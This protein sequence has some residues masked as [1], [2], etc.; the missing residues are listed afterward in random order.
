M[1]LA[2]GFLDALEADFEHIAPTAFTDGRDNAAPKAKLAVVKDWATMKNL[3]DK[4]FPQIPPSEYRLGPKSSSHQRLK[5]A[6]KRENFVGKVR[7]MSPERGGHGSANAKGSVAEGSSVVLVSDLAAL[8][9]PKYD[10]SVLSNN[11]TR[12]T[13]YDEEE[14]DDEE[15]AAGGGSKHNVVNPNGTRG[16]NSEELFRSQVLPGWIYS[17]GWTKRPR[18]ATNVSIAPNQVS[19]DIADSALKINEA[20]SRR[21]VQLGKK[22]AASFGKLPTLERARPP[23]YAAQN[24]HVKKELAR[25]RYI[26]VD[27]AR[28]RKPGPRYNLNPVRNQRSKPINGKRSVQGTSLV[29]GFAKSITGKAVMAYPSI[30]DFSNYNLGDAL[31]TNSHSQFD[32][33]AE[34]LMRASMESMNSGAIWAGRPTFGSIYELA[35]NQGGPGPAHNVNESFLQTSLAHRSERAQFSPINSAPATPE[36]RAQRKAQDLPNGRRNPGRLSPQLSMAYK[37]Y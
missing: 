8:D 15:D 14:Y 9:T 11:I 29:T 26:W 17:Q 10:E 6:E 3:S 34:S 2:D 35:S 1:S 32:K 19:R 27:L 31:G 23:S 21:P 5:S 4:E 37:D 7:G 25:L 36:E 33:E 22:Y 12:N 28:A 13:S 20:R 24:D 16:Q 18:P 30:D